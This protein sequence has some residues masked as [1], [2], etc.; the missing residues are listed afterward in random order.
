MHEH[1]PNVAMSTR[2]LDSDLIFLD[3]NFLSWLEVLR[4]TR[5]VYCKFPGLLE[6]YGLCT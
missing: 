3:L 1:F 6:A 5:R 2:S 4:Q